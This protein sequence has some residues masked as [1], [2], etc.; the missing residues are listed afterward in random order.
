MQRNYLPGTTQKFFLGSKTKVSV[1]YKKNAKHKIKELITVGTVR[2]Y[3]TVLASNVNVWGKEPIVLDHDRTL[4]HIVMK[5][6]RTQ[7]PVAG[8]EYQ[9]LMIGIHLHLGSR[10]WSQRWI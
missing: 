7:Y 1:L 9:Y 6:T 3:C 8:N 2:Q 4:K 5:V 10:V